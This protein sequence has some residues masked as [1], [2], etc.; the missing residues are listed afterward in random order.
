MSF[1]LE[2]RDGRRQA[3]LIILSLRGE[4]VAFKVY[5]PGGLTF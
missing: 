4:R 3:T 5:E 2:H 1:A